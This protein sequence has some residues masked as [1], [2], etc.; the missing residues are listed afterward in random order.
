MRE[1]EI[2]GF[3]DDA[4]VPGLG[5]PDPLGGEFQ[6]GVF[7]EFGGEAVCGQLDAVAGDPGEADLQVVPLRP[8]GLHV[9]GLARR[10]G[11]RGDRLGGEVEG[12][13]E[14]VRVL[15]G[16]QPFPVRFVGLAAQGASDHLLAEQLRPE[17]P[18]PQHV[19]DGAGV[20]SLA[21]HGHG[22][23]AA[24]RIPEPSRLADGVHDLA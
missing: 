10:P 12:D 19:G 8:D 16:E 24:D 3:A 15:D 4:C 23:D 13:A 11:R 18:H 9:H 22:D 17:G 7:V 5:G 1:V 6:H 21:Q 2:H 20:P 14:H